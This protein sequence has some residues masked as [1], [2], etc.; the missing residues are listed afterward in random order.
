MSAGE[1]AVRAVIAAAA[2]ATEVAVL[3]PS[4]RRHRRGRAT[5]RPPEFVADAGSR[6]LGPSRPPRPSAARATVATG[7]RFAES[8]LSLSERTRVN[9]WG[10]LAA[11]SKPFQAAYRW[12][13]SFVLLFT[14]GVLFF[15]A[16]VVALLGDYSR[17]VLAATL[18][19]SA[20]LVGLPALKLHRIVWQALNLSAGAY[21]VAREG[22]GDVDE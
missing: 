11:Q 4:L 21:L 10:E 7:A 14:A 3:V 16:S 1:I 18:L 2:G 6:P 17:I 5:G 19:A 13:K 15:T 9:I 12:T 20:V 22:V 8:A